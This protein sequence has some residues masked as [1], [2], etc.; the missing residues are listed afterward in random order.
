MKPLNISWNPA[1][2]FAIQMTRNAP[3]TVEELSTKW[4]PLHSQ[5]FVPSAVISG[6]PSFKELKDLFK[7]ANAG[8]V[9]VTAFPDR[10]IMRSFLNQIS[11]ETEVWV[12]DDADH[13]IHFN[14][15]RFLGPYPDALPQ[16]HP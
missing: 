12:A 10:D 5:C 3:P 11:W 2:S 16:T 6:K 4:N 1:C 9:F 14:G 13:L 7:G 15:E 8:L